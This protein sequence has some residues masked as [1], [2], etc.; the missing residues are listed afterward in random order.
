MFI[1]HFAIGFAGKAVNKKM[2]LGTMFLA[3]Q[4]LDLLW[5]VLVLTGIEKVSI[6]PGNTVSTPLNFEYYPWSHSML[7]AGVWGIL[8]ALIYYL[9]K[10]DGKGALLMLLLVFSHWILD[11]VTHRPDLP[12]TPFDDTTK[13]G[14]GL[15]N[16]KWAG[17]A[18]ETS[19]FLAGSLIYMNVT[20]AR[21][22]TGKW[23]LWALILFLLVIHFMNM[24][25]PPPPS[26][27][28]IGWAGL[29]LWL[30]VLWGYWTDRNRE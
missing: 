2:S 23:S 6:E 18:I 27:T 8:F 22:N 20:K 13:V 26:V 19:M 5:P 7:M 30:F 17:I 9:V 11:W 14:L 4:W 21:N 29:L 12:I 16:H 1:G 15:W 28:A 25:G 10:K 3:I 24:F